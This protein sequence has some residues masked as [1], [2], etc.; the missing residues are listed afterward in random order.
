VTR[1]PLPSTDQVR[2]LPSYFPQR[3]PEKFIDENGHMNITHYF[4]LGAWAP[5]THLT[6]LGL[7]QTYIDQRASSF[8]TVEHHIR[9]TGELLLDDSF[10]VRVGFAGRTSKAVHAVSFVLDESHDRV[11]CVM[12]LMYVHV[13]MES[14]RATDMPDDIAA[15]LDAEIAPNPWVA[16]AVGGLSLR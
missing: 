3:V 15:L 7:G 13:S 1:L 16:D 8:F 11:S 5:W 6:D 2:T 4:G 14:R 12:E 9:Y 10:S